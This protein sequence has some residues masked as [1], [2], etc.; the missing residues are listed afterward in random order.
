MHPRVYI[1]GLI[2]A[3]LQRFDLA[4]LAGLEEQIW[5]RVAEPSP[6]LS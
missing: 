6:W 5:P 2:E 4:V 3:R 1:L